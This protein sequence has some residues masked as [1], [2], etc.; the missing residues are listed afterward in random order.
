M[1][2]LKVWGSA[3]H[4]VVSA[5]QPSLLGLRERVGWTL[6]RFLPHRARDR[7]SAEVL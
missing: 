2:F 3:P 1:A 7:V 5:N 6:V 4:R